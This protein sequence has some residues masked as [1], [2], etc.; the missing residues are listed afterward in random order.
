MSRKT[1]PKS[2]YEKG[3][4]GL[5]NKKPGNEQRTSSALR[6]KAEKYLE[7]R[8]LKPDSI[9][10]LD[11]SEI[12]ILLHELQVH[13]IELEM[14]NEELRG[15]Q[16][17]LEELKDKYVD[18]YDLAPVGYVTI[19]D[20]GLVIES[21]QTFAHLLGI[22]RGR[23]LGRTFFRFVAQSDHLAYSSH[24]Q[25]LLDRETEQTCELRL[26]RNDGSLFYA[27]LQSTP[28]IGEGKSIGCRTV[29]SDITEFKKADEALRESEE[30]HRAIF[31][32]AGIGIDIVGQD[33]RFEHVNPALADMLGYTQE[34]LR[35]LTIDQITH[36]ED[37]EPS[38]S[39]LKDL[40]QGKIDSYRLEKRYVT[41]NGDIIWTDV[42]VSAM[43]DRDGRNVR[44]VGIISDITS[45]KNAEMAL[46]D[47][48]EKYRL[49]VENANEAIFIAQGDFIKF[50]N[51]RTVEILGYSADELASIPI[52]TL[53]HAADR[54]VLLERYAKR[55]QGLPVEQAYPFRVITKSGIT[56]WVELNAVTIHWNGRP[57]TLSLGND[58]TE[59]KRMREAQS[60]LM[61]AVEQAAEGIVITD[62]QGTVQY[63]NPAYA[64]I[65]GYAVEEV[66]G[67]N[68]HIFK[69]GKHPDSFYKDMWDTISGGRTWSGH[70]INRKKDGSLFE[71]EATISPVRD[72]FG[73]II[74]YVAAKRDVT[75][76]KALQRELLQAQKMEAVGTLAGGVAHDFNN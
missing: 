45:R 7:N 61:T 43:R 19:N 14:Q 47:S 29:V 25:G 44:D 1:K 33:G 23:L 26:I 10:G 64:E 42:S 76:E 6:T 18:L 2:N 27:R 37:F 20:L 67:R 66:L 46:R 52:E 21:N 30:R 38:R 32:N 5:S 50:A 36:P 16:I 60:R 71:E 57:A 11:R 35:N 41:K 51:P 12:E 74:N 48:E 53:I 72:A 63:V 58:I 59:R 68:S 9:S 73:D 54:E 28:V 13:Q 8:L 55:L 15:A 31:N 56:R 62:A 39:K 4:S 34:E 17:K 75:H 65:T 22:P 40:F 3:D 49:V 70:L 24:R 69:S